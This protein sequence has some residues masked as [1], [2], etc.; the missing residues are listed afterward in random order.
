MPAMSLA[1]TTCS[2]LKTYNPRGRNAWRFCT[3]RSQGSLSK[4]TSS[5]HH[6]LMRNLRNEGYFKAAM[7]THGRK[8]K[9]ARTSCI[10]GSRLQGLIRVELVTEIRVQCLVREKEMKG[11]HI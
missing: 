9:L 6:P 5:L 4:F 11:G 10:P 3:E 2:V 1:L 8:T 7:G